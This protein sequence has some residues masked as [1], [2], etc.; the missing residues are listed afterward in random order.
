MFSFSDNKQNSGY[1]SYVQT[2]NM[3]CLQPSFTNSCHLG[4]GLKLRND[5][6]K[7]LNHF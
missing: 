4:Q 3:F 5:T 2:S 7:S 1:L 6:F